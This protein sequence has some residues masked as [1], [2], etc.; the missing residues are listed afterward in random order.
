MLLYLVVRVVLDFRGYLFFAKVDQLSSDLFHVDLVQRLFAEELHAPV[1][2]LALPDLLE[3]LL[4][5]C[6]QLFL[7]VRLVQVSL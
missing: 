5:L 1:L 2:K 3:L 6:L 4:Y 7:Q